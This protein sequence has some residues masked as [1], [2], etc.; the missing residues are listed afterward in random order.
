MLTSTGEDEQ[1]RIDALRSAQT[2]TYHTAA[3]ILTHLT[4]QPTYPQT[5]ESYDRNP[6]DFRVWVKFD[7]PW[8]DRDAADDALVQALGFLE[9]RCSNG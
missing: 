7:L 1:I 9:E 6:E 4:L 8:T 3:Y 5:G 2:G